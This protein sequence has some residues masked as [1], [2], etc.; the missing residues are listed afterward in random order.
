M[1]RAQTLIINL[2]RCSKLIINKLMLPHPK[3]NPEIITNKV[4]IPV[5]K[6][7]VVNLLQNTYKSAA[8][9][10]VGYGGHS[11]AMLEK[12]PSLGLFGVDRDEMAITSCSN[13]FSLFKSRFTLFKNDF[14]SQLQLWLNQEQKFDF[15]LADLG[16]S[17]LQLDTT[18]RGFSFTKEA[19]LDMRMDQ[20]QELTAYEVINFYPLEKLGKIF[21]NY[22]EEKHWK[23]L[24]KKIGLTREKKKITTTT[25]L[26]NLILR[27]LPK[28]NKPKIHPATLIFQALRIEVN[29][30]LEIL[31]NMLP[32]ALQI[33]KKRGRLV[34][35]SFHSLEDRI[36]K[37]QFKNWANPPIKTPYPLP[38]ETPIPLVKLLTKKPLVAQQEEIRVN[39]RSRSAKL[40]VIEKI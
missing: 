12:L 9:L 40:R 24:T 10:T 5:L 31:K 1:L 25:E 30:E 21:L 36:I 37:Q 7:E 2:K 28:K 22:G 39:P 27:Y 4:H 16:V 3:I 14:Y 15:I 13:N 23:I 6:N 20:K 34:I 17:S 33:L 19:K 35:I 8:D 32:I 11:Y 26:S 29:N 38:A 18:E